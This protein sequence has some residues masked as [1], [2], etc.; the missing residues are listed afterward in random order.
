MCGGVKLLDSLETDHCHLG[1]VRQ[2]VSCLSTP[3][4]SSSLPCF[5]AC[6]PQINSSYCCVVYEENDRWNRKYTF[7]WRSEFPLR[8]RPSSRFEEHVCG[9]RERDTAHGCNLKMLF[10]DTLKCGKSKSLSL[11]RLWEGKPEI[12]ERGKF[13]SPDGILS[14]STKRGFWFSGGHR[15]VES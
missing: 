15:F 2:K 11:G 5:L 14:L 6:I 4:L 1:E 7:H 13:R 3:F 12:W 8:L 10:L 9:R